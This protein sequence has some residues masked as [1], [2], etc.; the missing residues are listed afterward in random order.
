MT[1][2]PL[3]AVL[4]Q[5]DYQPATGFRE[6]LRTQLLADIATTNGQPVE[7]Q[8]DVDRADTEPPQEVTVL[9]KVDHSQ[10][11]R[12]RT[13]LGVAAALVVVAGATAVIANRMHSADDSNPFTGN[14]SSIARA[15]LISVDQL[16]PGWSEQ[17]DT[18]DTF[19]QWH[20]VASAQPECA[21]FTAGLGTTATGAKTLLINLQSQ[22]VSEMLSL[23][24]SSEA[25]S[26]AM[27]SAEA[28]GFPVC[29]FATFDAI[30]RIY[31][32]DS[33]PTTRSFAIAPPTPHGD[34]QIDFGMESRTAVDSN[35]QLFHN[36]WIQVD[37]AVIQLVVSPDGLKSD[38]PNGLL[39]RSITAAIASLDEAM[40]GQK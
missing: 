35:V 1:Q 21:D 19:E 12:T 5:L 39:E 38:D 34:R 6:T 9:K 27:D 29:W 22:E 10:S 37:R 24:S 14:D 7:L 33:G 2:H 28:P 16:G 8:L 31:F 30:S 13:L 20:E 17:A 3:R 25:A 36:V 11:R 15:A 32:P 26:R 23:Y 4:T 40:S 18:T